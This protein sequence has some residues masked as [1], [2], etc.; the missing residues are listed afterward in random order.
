MH[1]AG[2]RAV[3]SSSMSLCIYRH[4]MHVQSFENLPVKEAVLFGRILYLSSGS[5]PYLSPFK[6]IQR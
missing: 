6:T 1:K 2:Q 5:P 4:H 3:A